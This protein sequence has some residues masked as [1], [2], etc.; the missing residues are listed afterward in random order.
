MPTETTMKLGEKWTAMAAAREVMG[1]AADAIR[2]GQGEHWLA[3]AM[4]LHIGIARD[5]GEWSHAHET[6]QAWLDHR[7][8]L[9]D[10]PSYWQR[11]E[12]VASDIRQAYGAKP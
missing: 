8:G 2:D 6:I 4:A 9:L 5:R 10:K 11:L 3:V 1:G 7:D 12:D